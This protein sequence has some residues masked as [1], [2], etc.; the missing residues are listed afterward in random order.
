MLTSIECDWSAIY[1]II[2]SEYC[3]GTSGRQNH[4]WIG[5]E[6]GAVSLSSYSDDVTD[7]MKTE[8]AIA[9]D[10]ITGG[11]DVFSGVIF[12]NKGELRCMR[13]ERMTDDNILNNVDWLEKGEQK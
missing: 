1:S 6:D 13:G 2:L 4:Y 5:I 12:D 8:V 7:V 10:E 9:K 11:R 3:K